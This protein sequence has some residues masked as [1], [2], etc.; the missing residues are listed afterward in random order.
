ML[1]DPNN[2]RMDMFYIGHHYLHHKCYNCHNLPN[3][4]HHR[5][6]AEVELDN[7]DSHKDLVDNR[8]AHLDHSLSMLYMSLG[9][10]SLSVYHQDN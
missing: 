3:R 4:S 7:F 2:S 10:Y 8:S 9:M 1:Q 5:L 6:V